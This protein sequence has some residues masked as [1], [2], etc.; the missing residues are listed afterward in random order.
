MQK[1]S[2]ALQSIP[3]RIMITRK[4]LKLDQGDMAILLNMS[5]NNYSTIENGRCG[6]NLEYILLIHE[7]FH[8]P[9][10]WLLKGEGSVPNPT[11]D[12]EALQL[13]QLQG[14]DA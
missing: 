1:V 6:I 4:R 3:E 7:F 13:L 9:L 11:L 2:N 12:S 14:F 5:R 8:V 10:D